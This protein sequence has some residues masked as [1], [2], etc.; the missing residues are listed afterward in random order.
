MWNKTTRSF[1]QS[2]G[3]EIPIIQSLWCGQAGS[4]G[5]KLPSKE[6]LDILVREVDASFGSINKIKD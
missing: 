2:L 4:L 5:R 1:C 6:L 3:I